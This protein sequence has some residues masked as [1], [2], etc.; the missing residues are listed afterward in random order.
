MLD[1]DS[2]G[3]PINSRTRRTVDSPIPSDRAGSAALQI[4]PWLWAT[5]VQNRNNARAGI[6][7][8]LRHIAFEKRLWELLPP[9]RAIFIGSCKKGQREPPTQPMP[10]ESVRYHEN[11]PFTGGFSW[12]VPQ[13]GFEVARQPTQ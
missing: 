13:R 5:I 6:D 7:A 9:G 11:P 8:E 3:A 10:V 12:M 1:S 4:P 2:L